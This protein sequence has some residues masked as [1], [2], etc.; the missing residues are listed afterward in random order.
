MWG[1]YFSPLSVFQQGTKRVHEQFTSV[2]V[3]IIYFYVICDLHSK[4]K[5]KLN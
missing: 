3:G 2:F 1:D 5:A 4:N